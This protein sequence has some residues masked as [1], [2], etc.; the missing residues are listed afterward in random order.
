MYNGDNKPY[1]SSGTPGS[2]MLSETWEISAWAVL[3][4]LL[5]PCACGCCCLLELEEQDDLQLGT[6]LE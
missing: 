3:I 6:D 4:I 1:L 5:S 2:T